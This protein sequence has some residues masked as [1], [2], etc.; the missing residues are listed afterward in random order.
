MSHRCRIMRE[1]NPNFSESTIY[2]IFKNRKAIETIGGLHEFIWRTQT[3]KNV[4]AILR[5]HTVSMNSQSRE[6]KL[7]E[8]KTHLSL[9]LCSAK[10]KRSSTQ[11]PVCIFHAKTYNFVCLEL[12]RTFCFCIAPP[13]LRFYRLQ[14]A[15]S[16]SL[17]C[18]SSASVMW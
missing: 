16:A 14:S 7:I 17:R 5:A 4:S 6:Y 12:K 2:N 1:E 3:S 13:S 18:T 8:L 15:P 9:F 10:F 11:L